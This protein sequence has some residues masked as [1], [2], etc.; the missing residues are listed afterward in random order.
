MKHWALLSLLFYL[1][2]CVQGEQK[3]AVSEGASVG[4]IQPSQ[5]SA[6]GY[7]PPSPIPPEVAFAPTPYPFSYST[8]S[9]PLKVTITNSNN[10]PYTIEWLRNGIQTTPPN[11]TDSFLVTPTQYPLGTNTVTSVLRDGSGNILSTLVWS[12]QITSASPSYD[13]LTPLPSPAI[14]PGLPIAPWEPNET[15]TA[16]ITNPGGYTYYHIWFLDGAVYGTPS[17]QTGFSR[18]TFI[19]QPASLSI[20]SHTITSSIRSDPNP[21]VGTTFNTASWNITIANVPQFSSFSDQLPAPAPFPDIDFGSAT[22]VLLNP[23]TLSNPQ[24]ATFTINWIVDGATDTTATFFNPGGS[25]IDPPAFEVNA[26]STTVWDPGNHSVQALLYDT[27]NKLV[28]QAFWAFTILYPPPTTIDSVLPS[29]ATF[30]SAIQNIALDNILPGF[31]EGTPT[32]SFR[33]TPITASGTNA[34]CVGVVDGRG[35][36][37]AAFPTIA[38]VQIQFKNGTNGTG[39][40]LTGALVYQR[41]ANPADI[42]LGSPGANPGFTISLASPNSYF[43]TANVVDILSLQTVGTV[44]WT[45]KVV[46]PNTPPVITKNAIVP[47]TV[48]QNATATFSFTVEDQDGSAPPDWENF[49]ST[50]NFKSPSNSSDV[51]VNGGT[52]YGGPPGSTP[53]TPNCV[54][55]FPDPDPLKFTCSIIIPA[56]NGNSPALATGTFT[57]T[58]NVTNLSIYPTAATPT[59]TA[60]RDLYDPPVAATAPAIWTFSVTESNVGAPTLQNIFLDGAADPSSQTYMF[61]S[62]TPLVASISASETDSIGFTF[63]LND[64]EKDNFTV[65]LY[66]NSAATPTTFVQYYASPAS[67]TFTI[68]Q[69][70]SPLFLTAPTIPTFYL[71]EGVVT[72]AAGA[73]ITF[74]VVLTDVPEM[75]TTIANTSTTTF[76]IWVNNY[77]P[78]PVVASATYLPPLVGTST[79]MEGFPFTFVTPPISDASTMDGNGLLWQWMVLDVADCASG[80]S[81]GAYVPGWKSI[82]G[83]TNGAAPIIVPP[84]VSA[85]LTWSSPGVLNLNPSCALQFRNCIG[86]NGFGNT[87]NPATCAAA[88]AGPWDGPVYGRPADTYT[89]AGAYDANADEATAAWADPANVGMIYGAHVKGNVITLASYKYQMDTTINASAISFTTDSLD[90]ITASSTEGAYDLS[91]IGNNNYIFVSYVFNNVSTVPPYVG[92]PTSTVVRIAKTNMATATVDY[93]VNDDV[94]SGVG[95]VVANDSA[96]WVPY[97]NASQSDIPWV[98]YGDGTGATPTTF[99]KSKL[100]LG[101]GVT[102]SAMNL[103]SRTDYNNNLYLAAK[104]PDGTVNAYKYNMPSS[105]SAP[106]LT[107]TNQ[108]IFFPYSPFSEMTLAVSSTSTNDY[109]FV[110]AKNTINNKL[111]YARLKRADVSDDSFFDLS[112]IATA[113]YP[114]AALNDLGLNAVASTISGEFILGVIKDVG[115]ITN[116]YLLKIKDLSIKSS[117][118]VNAR[119]GK[120]FD[121]GDFAITNIIPGFTI[122]DAG[123]IP[124]E[125]TK[126]TLWFRYNDD[127]TQRE[128]IINTQDEKFSN[129]AAESNTN[130]WGQPWFRAP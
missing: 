107:N 41:Q 92:I 113:T 26:A 103:Q 47:A 39:T 100:N 48:T 96:F 22:I 9:I 70:T 118:Q 51:I 14:Y 1:A 108:D 55:D 34:F 116:S 79:V 97:I 53:P 52:Y 86:D 124:G 99:S 74:Q 68:A 90:P 65:K 40:D 101:A 15:I 85:T 77:N 119:P 7:P 19:I 6:P 17:S 58:A 2:S 76:E 38:G 80:T 123:A 27:T 98:I 106:T 71:D 115:G 129:S 84:A 105:V 109:V 75:P 117:R 29:T 4:I 62:G 46:A 89:T 33:G 88:M 57:V 78:P 72:G 30:V 93:F 50:F 43:L 49:D 5:N 24:N 60:P 11:N 91:I 69:A 45:I 73:T 61:V 87:L 126:N 42:C 59:Y 83:A 13:S 67:P 66:H 111:F 82:T 32:N 18:Q 130:L 36:G 56:A 104:L 110:A 128:V 121:S 31:F 112:S 120:G 127:S 122:G 102:L 25:N 63:I 94:V 10:L 95:Q 125:N 81:G 12:F 54:R 20:G 23:N 35:V 3:S 44:N 16:D 37:Y 114:D 28:G 21:T 8:P 64:L